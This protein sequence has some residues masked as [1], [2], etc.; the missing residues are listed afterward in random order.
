[1]RVSATTLESFRLF[2]DEDFMSED[3]IL[4]TIRGEFRP[5]RKMLLGLAFGRAIERP[6]RWR[7]ENGYEVFV[8]NEQDRW[9]GFKFSEQDLAPALA[10]FDR[11]GV[12]EVKSTLNYGGVDIVA[13][14]DQILGTVIIENKTKTSTFN[15]DKY[16]DSYQ[17]RYMLDIFKTSQVTYN[18]FELDENADESEPLIKDTHV[19]NF[20]PYP[21]LHKDCCDLLARFLGYVATRNL[22]PYL[23]EKVYA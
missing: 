13:K 8:K 11:R 12:F 17:W 7:T 23:Q 22:E 14:A 16:A 21:D 15:F 3:E 2:A 9:E 10:R 1:M 4:A 5:T 20:Y 19:F 18:V 6:T